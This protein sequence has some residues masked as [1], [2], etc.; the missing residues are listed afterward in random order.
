MM[1]HAL[2]CAVPL[3][4]DHTCYL[5]QSLDYKTQ[6]WKIQ[7]QPYI[8]EDGFPSLED[9]KEGNTSII[10]SHAL[11]LVTLWEVTFLMWSLVKY[12]ISVSSS[13][14]LHIWKW[15]I[16]SFFLDD[17][18]LWMTWTW[19]FASFWVQGN[20]C[21]FSGDHGRYKVGEGIWTSW[22]STFSDVQ[23]WR[24][25][26]K[27]LRKIEMEE[28]ISNHPK[29]HTKGAN[30]LQKAKWAMKSQENDVIIPWWWV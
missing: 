11:I 15:I 12:R 2:I 18:F 4:R 16:I 27:K 26:F 8:S 20:T 10:L 25:T 13:S 29:R 21:I 1:G 28:E 6:A 30:H 19:D 22:N 23:I 7:R 24:G 17:I 3:A 9:Q 5:S 14:F